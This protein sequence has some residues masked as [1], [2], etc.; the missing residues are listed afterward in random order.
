MRDLVLSAGG[1]EFLSIDS[2]VG[3]AIRVAIAVVVF[4]LG[5]LAGASVAAWAMPPV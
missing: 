4:F 5:V 3:R 1:R 2:D